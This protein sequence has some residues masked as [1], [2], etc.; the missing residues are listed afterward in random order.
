MRRAR[1]GDERGEARL[2]SASAAPSALST[3][4]DRA[5]SS[6]SNG[7]SSAGCF[8][9]LPVTTRTRRS[10][11]AWALRRKLAE[12]AMRGGFRH[13]MQIETRI[14]FELPAAK[15]FRRSSVNSGLRR[16]HA[17]RRLRLAVF[18]FVFLGGFLRGRRKMRT[19]LAE[20]L[21]EERLFFVAGF[22]LA[23]CHCGASRNSLPAPSAAAAAFGTSTK[24]CPCAFSRPA[25]VSASAPAPKKIS[26]R[27]APLM[28]PPV[29]CAISNL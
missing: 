8:R 28:A 3:P 6:R 2:P 24:N 7:S 4:R 23:P 22:A 26:P 15:P 21:A 13:A 27:A 16:P 20:C 29:S 17:W 18:L 19:H 1:V 12:C 25:I 5:C 9:P 14:R 10:P 11:C